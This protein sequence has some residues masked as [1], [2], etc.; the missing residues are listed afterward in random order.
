MQVKVGNFFGLLS[1]EALV[2]VL[3]AWSDRMFS[4]S[5]LSVCEDEL[6]GN[7]FRRLVLVA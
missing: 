5:C 7:E 2:F 1:L 3:S 4:K 6:S